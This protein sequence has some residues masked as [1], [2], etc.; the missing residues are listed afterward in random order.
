MVDDETQTLE[1]GERDPDIPMKVMIHQF[2]PP[3]GPATLVVV[4]EA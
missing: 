1:E 2:L 4:G 3:R